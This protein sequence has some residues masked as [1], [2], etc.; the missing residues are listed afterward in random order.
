MVFH[1]LDALQKAGIDV[2]VTGAA[3]A[4]LDLDR[5]D[6]F[7]CVVLENVPADDLPVGAM[8]VLRAWVSD[9]GGGLL[10]TGGQASFGIGG[11]HRSPVEEVLPVTMEV[12][13]TRTRRLSHAYPVY[14]IGYEDKFHAV[15]AW[16]SQLEGILVFGRQGLFA[17][18][19]THHAFAMAYAA[20]EV[21]GPDGQIDRARWAE[22]RKEFES[23]R[24]ED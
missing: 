18:D 5:L 3:S 21:I 11:Y 6:G 1:L 16:L 17:H 8:D 13:G 23:H 19:N 22:H 15:D 2:T 12:L 24:V 20:A 4:P 7:R 9:F 14:D 10:M